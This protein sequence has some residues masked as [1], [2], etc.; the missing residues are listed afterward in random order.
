MADKYI[1]NNFIRLNKLSGLT[2][3]SSKN[4]HNNF[5]KHT[6]DELS[7]DL[8]KFFENI[9]LQI[10]KKNYEEAKKLNLDFISKVSNF[11]PAWNSL[12]V[13]HSSI[14]DIDAAK[15]YFKKSLTLN[16][17]NINA[18]INLGNIHFYQND[19][20]E[21][22]I[23][24]RKLFDLN[25]VNFKLVDN[26]IALRLVSCYLAIDRYD[27]A[28]KSFYDLLNAG[29]INEE[30]Y[31]LLAQVYLKKN[32][33]IN[34][35]KVYFLALEIDP[36]SSVICYNIGN[37]YQITGKL[38][39]SVYYFLKSIEYDEFYIP[40]FHA[41]SIMNPELIKDSLSKNMEDLFFKILKSNNHTNL[42]INKSL[43]NINE[44]QL[45]ISFVKLGYG[46]FNYFEF[47]GKYDEAFSFLLEANK[48]FYKYHTNSIDFNN[49]FL[50]PLDLLLDI[51]RKVLNK[52]FSFKSSNSIEIDKKLIFIVGMPRSGTTLVEQILSS[53]SKIMGLGERNEMPNLFVF[54]FKY[55]GLNINQS[56]F[57]NL[58]INKD[59][60]P[61]TLKEKLESLSAK[62]IDNFRDYYLKDINNFIQDHDYVID[63]MP[64]NFYRIGLISTLFPNATIIHIKRDGLDTCF[65]NFSTLFSNEHVYSYNLKH[66]GHYYN[67]YLEIMNYWEN[68]KV[69]NY[70]ALEYEN[71]INNME[72]E[73]KKIINNIGLVFEIGCLD[74]YK[75]KRDIRTAS[76]VQVRKKLYKS[77]INKSKLYD[78][79][80]NTLNNIL[81]K[82]K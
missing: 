31:S 55:L 20:P 36:K 4:G 38:S 10:D 72:F 46:L 78:N 21:A 14:S 57:K 29:Y 54:L 49:D 23:C 18:L 22:I 65:S 7:T 37:L 8:L 62:D 26:K 11:S 76:A 52:S 27:E 34:A 51:N 41:L 81:L 24:F 50:N 33:Y 61:Q 59:F 1:K 42:F 82:N 12:G 68:N 66:M 73:I 19:Y 63:K 5:V 67:T 16:T 9:L 25:T 70:I 40:A 3:I 15:S 58:N 45:D 71:I 74:F 44:K 13:I 48:F 53:H 64:S 2:K 30:N 39:D 60:D 32:D 17:N 56:F 43:V 77:S 35:L 28:I 6:L 80:L 47:K 69:D 79:N 75:N